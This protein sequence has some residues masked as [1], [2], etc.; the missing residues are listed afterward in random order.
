MM[1]WDRVFLTLLPQ[2]MRDWTLRFNF[3]GVWEEWNQIIFPKSLLSWS[4]LSPEN[5][6]SYREHLL[7]PGTSN[8]SVLLETEPLIPG[9]GWYLHKEPHSIQLICWIWGC[10]KRYFILTFPFFSND[11]LNSFKIV[12]YLMCPPKYLFHY[13]NNTVSVDSILLAEVG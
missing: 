8:I 12:C 13:W 1:K 9:S 6:S 7:E 3:T 2:A 10:E 11:F 4:H 5:A